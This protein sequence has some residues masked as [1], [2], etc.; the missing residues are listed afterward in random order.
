MVKLLGAIII[1]FVT[2]LTGFEFANNYRN[3]TKYLRQFK[4]A[5]QSLSAEI[6]YGHIPLVE[7]TK[8]ISKQVDEPISLF[9]ETFSK[10]LSEESNHVSNLWKECLE[11]I[12]QKASLKTTEFEVLSQFGETLG[13]HDLESQ[14]KHIILAMNHLEKIEIEARDN[15]QKYENMVRSLGFLAGVLI[16]LLLL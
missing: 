4:F 1:I 12:R 15:Q 14:Q 16:V 6:M 11:L 2:T 9:F 13:R 7:A 5:L 10:K 3:R 8:R